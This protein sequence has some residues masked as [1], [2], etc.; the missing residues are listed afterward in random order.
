MWFLSLLGPNT[1]LNILRKLRQLTS[2][3]III[4]MEP[5]GPDEILSD[6]YIK[7]CLHVGDPVISIHV[8]LLRDASFLLTNL[9]FSAL[10]T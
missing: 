9:N 4:E 6:S 3:Y 1:I 8:M 2:R 7:D 5:T 10:M